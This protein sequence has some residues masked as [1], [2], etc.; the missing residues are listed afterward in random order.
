M[1]ERAKGRAT[2]RG[3]TGR[4]EGRQEGKNGEDRSMCKEGVRLA[5]SLLHPLAVLLV[6]LDPFKP[7]SIQRRSRTRPIGH[8]AHVRQVVHRDL[9]EVD[10]R[11]DLCIE[12]GQPGGGEGDGEKTGEER[13]IMW[14]LR[15]LKTPKLRE[16]DG[17]G[18]VK[19]VCARP[20][21]AG[22]V[23]KVGGRGGGERSARRTLDTRV[24]THVRVARRG[25]TNWI[26]FARVSLEPAQ[27]RRKKADAHVLP[28]PSTSHLYV[29]L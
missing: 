29:R 9:A 6:L 8:E 16:Q 24:R 1:C 22:R 21:R 13:T 5:A 28:H 11:V 23:R 12:Q 10:R 14:R 27:E 25:T 18:Q 7:P 4:Q 17:I 3:R 15:L 26:E 20:A 2:V 19:A